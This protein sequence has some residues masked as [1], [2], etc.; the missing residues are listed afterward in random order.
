VQHGREPNAAQSQLFDL[1]IMDLRGFLLQGVF[2]V[3]PIIVFFRP[4]DAYKPT[5][6][7][8]REREADQFLSTFNI[9]KPPSLKPGQ[10]L[11]GNIADFTY[12]LGI[13][14]H[15]REHEQ[16][17]P[18]TLA[19]LVDTLEPHQR[20]EI[21]ITVLFT[22]EEPTENSA[23]GQPWLESIADSVMGYG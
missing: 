12:C 6:S 9:D 13:P 3:R 14:S 2:A 22:D 20:S 21:F 18:R 8:I 23:F 19:S 1:V 4:Q 16:F 15:R 7:A 11:P 17:F 10:S 5:H